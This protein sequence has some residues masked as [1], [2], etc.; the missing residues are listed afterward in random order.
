[1]DKAL[2]S[3]SFEFTEPLIPSLFLFLCASLSCLICSW[4][5][6]NVVFPWRR[7]L[8]TTSSPSSLLFLYVKLVK[9][10]HKQALTKNHRASPTCWLRL[11]LLTLSFYFGIK[12][13][14][15]KQACLAHHYSASLPL[16]FRLPKIRIFPGQLCPHSSLSPWFLSKSMLLQ[17]IMASLQART[18]REKQRYEGQLRLVAG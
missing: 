2:Q 3:L 5:T 6:S 14:S 11:P 10:R 15:P 17:I 12:C 16:G 4:E 9:L 18:G 7:Y 13:F 8:E 1:M